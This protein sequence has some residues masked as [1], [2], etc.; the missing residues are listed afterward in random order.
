M[1][2][3]KIY[4]NFGPIFKYYVLYSWKWILM[5]K[6]FSSSWNFVVGEAK[7]H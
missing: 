5:E 4:E 6:H 3:I 7:L 2:I 1:G